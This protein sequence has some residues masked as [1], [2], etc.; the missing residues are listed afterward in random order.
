M[1]LNLVPCCSQFEAVTEHLGHASLAEVCPWGWVWRFYSLTW[2]PALFPE[3]EWKLDQSASCS[4]PRTCFPCL[5]VLLPLKSQANILSFFLKLLLVMVFYHS[6]R[7]V[8]KTRASSPQTCLYYSLTSRRHLLLLKNQTR[9]CRSQAF[10]G[11]HGRGFCSHTE[12][13]NNL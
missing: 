9:L 10:L 5:D 6:T 13:Q 7:R 3:C 12:D 8:A 1:Y 2:L 11:V 4:C